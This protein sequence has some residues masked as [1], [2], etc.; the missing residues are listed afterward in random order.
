MSEARPDQDPHGPIATKVLYE[1]DQVRIWDQRL[2]PG[3]KTAPHTHDNDY[4]LVDVE[5]ERI[6]VEPLPGH[7]NV[8]YDSYL[9]LPVQRGQ[10]YTVGKG[11][12]EVASNI[13]S[14][15]YRAI[16]IEFKDDVG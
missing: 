3:E 2:D 13:G 9:E 14:R 11:S 12:V 7:N 5:G 6:G 16:L 15:R 1:D 10:A 4:V 8:D